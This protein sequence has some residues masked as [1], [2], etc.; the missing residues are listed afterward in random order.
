MTKIVTESNFSKLD[1]DQI[2]QFGI[3]HGL[4][5]VYMTFKAM[6]EW[7]KIKNT[8]FIS[9]STNLKKNCFVTF[10]RFAVSPS[11]IFTGAVEMKLKF[12]KSCGTPV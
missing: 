3:K 5:H 4:L 7:H 10:S 2:M 12:F 6:L 11:C 9:L 1:Y 8:D